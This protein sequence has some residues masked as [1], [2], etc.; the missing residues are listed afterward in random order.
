M[1]ANL[2]LDESIPSGVFLLWFTL[3]QKVLILPGQDVVIGGP[4][5]T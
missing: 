5:H 4:F 1:E 2:L 3:D